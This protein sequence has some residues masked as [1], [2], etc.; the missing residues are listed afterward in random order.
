MKK[1]TPQTGDI[2]SFRYRGYFL[3]GSPKLPTI[4]RIRRDLSW[5]DVVRNW[6]ERIV[7]PHGIQPTTQQHPSH[8]LFTALPLRKTRSATHPKGYWRHIENRRKFLREFADKMGFDPTVPENW[9]KQSGRLKA[10]GVPFSSPPSLHSTKII[11]SNTYH[12]NNK[13]KWA[14][15]YVWWLHGIVIS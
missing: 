1:W 4:Y 12:D 9:R 5:S 11:F 8:L 13:G 14:V 7:V 2:V 10:N 6:K 15:G 3:S